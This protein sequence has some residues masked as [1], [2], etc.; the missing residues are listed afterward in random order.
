MAPMR[1][2]GTRS[3][4]ASAFTDMSSGR[5]NS[6]RMISPGWVVTRF[7]AAILADL[8]VVDDF[9]MGWTLLGPG[10]T[11]PPLIV[12][13]DR[14]LTFTVACERFEPVARRGAQVIKLARGVDHVQFAPRRFFDA[15]ETLDELAHPEA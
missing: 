5:R 2:A 12:D 7:G 1:V 9:D 15:A 10:E 4:M 11:D 6:S 14:M 8:V 13:A 3:A